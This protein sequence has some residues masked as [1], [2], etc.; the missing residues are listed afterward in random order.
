MMRTYEIVSIPDAR[1]VGGGPGDPPPSS[2]EPG[3]LSPGLPR[4]RLV[5]DALLRRS[6]ADEGGGFQES[7]GLIRYFEEEEETVIHIDPRIVLGTGLVAAVAVEAL[8]YWFPVA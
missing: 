3:G 1:D 4:K 7:A 6:M 2:Q 8:H 5:P